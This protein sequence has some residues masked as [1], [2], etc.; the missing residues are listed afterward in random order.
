MREISTVDKRLAL[1]VLA[2]AIIGVAV[3]SLIVRE[4]GAN[5]PSDSIAALSIGAVVGGAGSLWPVFPMA[6]VSVF[7]ELTDWL[8]YALGLVAL[9]HLPELWNAA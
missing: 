6:G 9:Y 8:Y 5:P 7:D 2:G 3:A 1:R 4:A